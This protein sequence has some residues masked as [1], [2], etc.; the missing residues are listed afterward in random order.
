MAR[1]W[2]TDL[3][4]RYYDYSVLML[5]LGWTLHSSENPEAYPN[6]TIRVSGYAVNFHKLTKEQQ[7]EVISRTFHTVM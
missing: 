5:A 2:L 3:A 7:R 6:L 1:E 4:Q